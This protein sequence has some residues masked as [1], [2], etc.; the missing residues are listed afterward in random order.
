MVT[1]SR[2]NIFRT[3]FFVIAA[4]C[5]LVA[6]CGSSATT[7]GPS[8][9]NDNSPDS[10]RLADFEVFDVGQFSVQAPDNRPEIVHDVPEALLAGRA[11]AGVAQIVSGYRIQVFASAD[12]D[13]AL[14][15]EE[16]VHLWWEALDPDVKKRLDAPE[17]ITVY[18]QF[19]LPLYRIRIGDFTLRS[20]AERLMGIMAGSFET[21]FVVPDQVTIYR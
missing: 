21:V 3:G 14:E 5:F 9:E 19:K 7:T 17:K 20:R 2:A 8:V 11:D 4:F 6:G 12:L 16:R 1:L 15:V 18:N 13:A 10:I